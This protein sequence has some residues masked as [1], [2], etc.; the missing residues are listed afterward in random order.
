MSST[1]TRNVGIPAGSLEVKPPAHPSYD[2]KGLIQLALYQDAGGDVTCKATIPVEMEVEAHFLAKEDGIVAGIALVEM[3]FKELDPSPKVEWYRKDGD[4]SH[5]GLQFGKVHG[6]MAT[7]T[8]PAYILETR[9]TAPGLRLMDKWAVRGAESQNGFS[10]IC[11]SCKESSEAHVLCYT[12]KHANLTN[13][14]SVKL[15]GE[16]DGKLWMWHRCLWCTHVEGVPPATLR[17]VVSDAAWGLSFGKFLELSFSSHTTGNR[18]ASCGHSLQRDCLRFYGFGS[19]VAFFDILL[20]RSSLFVCPLRFLNSVAPVNKAG[21]EMRRM[22]G[23]R[24]STIC[25]GGSDLKVNEAA[26]GSEGTSADGPGIDFDVAGF[27]NESYCL[28]H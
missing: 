11:R 4:N 25:V 17:V 16:Q 6:G 19:M 28:L 20:S 2:L 24:C 10:N 18:V 23:I 26:M 7:A 3:V 13:L 12:R 22:R 15:P 5:K 27:T 14:P 1:A 8:H 9:K 21:S